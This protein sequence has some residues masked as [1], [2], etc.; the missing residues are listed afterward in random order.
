M[1]SF[2]STTTS[3]SSGYTYDEC[4]TKTLSK[5]DYEKWLNDEID[6]SQ[7]EELINKCLTG[8]IDFSEENSTETQVSRD[9]Q[10]PAETTD[11]VAAND[12]QTTTT[13]LSNVKGFNSDTVEEIEQ[14]PMVYSFDNLKDSSIKHSQ[15]ITSGT[16]S[17]TKVKKLQLIFNNCRS[18]IY[19]VENV[20]LNQ[21][22]EDFQLSSN[23]CKKGVDI[24]DFRYLQISNDAHRV[25]L[26][27]N[28][29]FG[30]KTNSFDCCHLLDMNELLQS[31]IDTLNLFFTTTT[32]TTTTTTIPYPPSVV[33]DSCPEVVKPGST[34]VYNY[35]VGGPSSKV[36]SIKFSI[37]LNSE[38]ALEEFIENNGNL[39]LPLQ[40]EEISYSYEYLVP[41][42]DN[43]TNIAFIVYAVNERG[44]PYE[45]TCN[46]KIEIPEKIPPDLGYLEVYGGWG[47]NNYDGMYAPHQSTGYLRDRTFRVKTYL[48]NEDSLKSVEFTLT[49]HESI[50]TVF[51]T[52]SSQFNQNT[53]YPAGHE[54][55][56]SVDYPSDEVRRFVPYNKTSRQWQGW[57]RLDV[58]LEDANGNINNLQFCK[59][60]R[61]VG[62]YQYY[63]G[64]VTYNYYN[65]S[66]QYWFEV[67]RNSGQC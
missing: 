38:I 48:L 16:F 36:V 34:L 18:T 21:T 24:S 60:L 28:G 35:K 66:T 5:G 62:G 27:S 65:Y 45:L 26:K 57:Y 64:S 52:C 37:L 50:G 23:S 22:S 33:F 4:V 14:W 20:E 63:S 54:I 58:R 19:T 55:T 13:K 1:F 47:Y 7:F 61:I 12:T 59:A 3:E 51:L 39:T 41:E 6:L 11:I 25:N 10:Q 30:K 2:C 44:N 15:D 53:M 31:F 67:S 40:S 46:T 29:E 32:T 9:S 8:E 56:C 43:E 49:P 42:V 17:G